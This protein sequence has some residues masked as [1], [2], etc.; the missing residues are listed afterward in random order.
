[1]TILIK[2]LSFET[3]IGILDIE[4][5]QKQRVSI[6]VTIDYEY[7]GT[8]INYADVSE[9]IKTAMHREQF[10]LIEEALL[11]LK[12]SLKVDFPLIKSL[13]LQISKPDILPDCEVCVSEHYKF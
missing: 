10:T 6:D 5:I 1:M 11:A 9:H 12:S 8:F 7:A 2:A 13:T 3:I 4:R